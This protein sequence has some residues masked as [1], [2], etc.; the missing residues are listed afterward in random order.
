MH[1]DTSRGNAGVFLAIVP[2]SNYSNQDELNYFGLGLVEELTVDLSHFPGLHIISSYTAKLLADEENTLEQARKLN[3][4]YLLEGGFHLSPQ[5]V[6]LSLRLIETDNGAVV[7]AERF[8]CP[9]PDLFA[10]QADIVERIVYS[11]PAEVEQ[12]MLAAAR[13]KNETSLAAYDCYLRGMARLRFG[14]LQADQEAREFFH[15]ALAID[16]YYSR[17]FAGLSL[18]YFNEWS[19]QLWDLYESSEQN[20]YKYAAKAF[21]LDDSDHIIHLILGRVYIYRRQFDEAEHHFERALALN[22]NDADC[23]VQLSTCFSFLGR[24]TKGEELF[25]K[26]LRLNPYRNLWYYQYGSFT[27]FV[28]RQFQQSIELALKRQLTNIW[29][30]LPGYIA[31][32]QAHLGNSSEAK[33]YIAMFVDSFTLSINRGR[34]PGKQE[35]LDWVTL[36]NPFRH[37]EDTACLVDG[38]LLAGLAEAVPSAPDSVKMI[39]KAAAAS[40]D[41]PAIFKQE[42]DVWRIEFDSV[43]VILPDLKGYH[44]LSRLLGNPEEDQH[45]TDLMGGESSMDE[46]MPVIDEQA[47]RAYNEHIGNLQQE[48]EEAEQFNDIGRKERLQEEL[49]QVVSHLH[50]SIGIGRKPRRLN[51][52][53]DRARAAVTQRIRSAIKKISDHHPALG[54]HLANSVRTGAF[55]RYSPEESPGWITS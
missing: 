51:A 41:A 6:R 42:Q 53:S 25:R 38:L 22:S 14:T 28:L 48:I 23:L 39:P 12:D 3:I 10:V 31:A 19:C 33:K 11:I 37:K 1:M 17:A 15:Q 24:A 46:N 52:P 49:E 55:C 20:A 16:P 34:T 29:V 40:Q 47:R 26:A 13:K 32:A 5:T 27:Y 36:A 8:D 9:L 54:R 45:C 21:Q 18:S 4:D 43:E 35:I 2:F 30:D 7:W 44:D 50:K